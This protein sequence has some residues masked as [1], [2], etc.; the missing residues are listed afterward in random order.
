[1]GSQDHQKPGFRAVLLSG[2]GRRAGE[3]SQGSFSSWPTSLSPLSHLTKM[4]E[5][6]IWGHENA[7]TGTKS[8]F[9]K[10][11]TGRGV[12]GKRRKWNLEF[13]FCRPST[14]INRT[15]AHLLR[16]SLNKQQL[17]LYLGVLMGTIS[18]AFSLQT[19]EGICRD[20]RIITALNSCLETALDG[21]SLQICHF[22]KN[23][24]GVAGSWEE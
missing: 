15:N 11:A 14:G 20:E 6:C 13:S 5:S 10:T 19:Q 3:G 9:L 8:Y 1:M 16:F 24:E 18:P 7:L 12:L 4:P 21:P 17:P 22:E 2:R 23:T